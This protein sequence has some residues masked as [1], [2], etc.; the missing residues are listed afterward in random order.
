MRGFLQRRRRGALALVA[1]AAMV[2]V[3][4][5][6]SANINTSQMVDDR[7]HSQD[8]A[9][10]LAKAHGV[11]SARA[12]NVIS[13]NN[14]TAAQ[15][16]GV[17]V[18]SEAL[19]WTTTELTIVATAAAGHIAGHAASQCRPYTS[20][21]ISIAVELAIWVPFCGA[22]H[23]AVGLPAA[24]A[25]G[26]SIEIRDNFD[27]VHGV[28]TATKALEAIDG[29][30][31]AL[32][33]RHPRAM[34][35]IAGHY[36][37]VLEIDDH[38]FADPCNGDGV[39]DCD[40]SNS[41]DGMALPLVEATAEARGQLYLLTTLGTTVRDTTFAARGFD[42]GTGPISAGGSSSRP[43]LK[44]YINHATE[45]GTALYDFDQFYK[46]RISDLPRHPLAGPGNAI[47]P[48]NRPP[49]ESPDEE[50][51]F[52]DDT[53]A[54]LEGLE[55][56]GEITEEVLRV[57]RN[58]PFAFDRHPRG[59]PFNFPLAQGR[60]DNN[61]FTRKFDM[62]HLAIM[63]GD[64]RDN[65]PVGL[66]GFTPVFAAPVPEIWELDG[67][68][69]VD[70]APPIEPATMPES[71]HVLA[72]SEMELSTRRGTAILSSPVQSHTGYGQVGVYN[73]D[74]ATLFTQN[75]QSRMMPATRLDDPS[76]MAGDL[77]RQATASFEELAESLGAVGSG[78]G[79]ER[80]NAH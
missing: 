72:F 26:R 5:M 71:F 23:T 39:A 64:L 70:P 45:I 41:R 76:A 8:A 31:R 29:M 10:A 53:T 58:L 24:V 46:D 36:R 60:R 49:S 11:W 52:D 37:E 44:D 68:G 34:A 62:F 43:Q 7:R 32:A 35:E 1:V 77:R 59:Y 80:V 42:T 28:Q 17:A 50:T 14:V 20:N 65:I 74:G 54:L 47:G 9:D 4:G 40:S 12:L 16:F 66:D 3:A 13:M 22:W 15:L 38:H 19:L 25:L 55:N 27:P 63:A 18:G 78:S 75:W 21:P 79:W 61:E 30:N 51:P 67:V 2:P 48:G 69:P 57:L 6:M 33:A 56:I 73:P